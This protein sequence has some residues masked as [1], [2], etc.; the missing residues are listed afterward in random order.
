M[1]EP[2]KNEP[3]TNESAEAAPTPH[4]EPDGRTV[5]QRLLR[6]FSPKAN[7]GQLLAGLL[8]AVLGFALVVQVR[9][10]SDDNLDTLRESDLV[11]ILD[12]VSQRTSRLEDETDELRRTRDELLS[13]SNQ[14]QVAQQAAQERVDLL[15]ILA[16]TAPATGPGIQLTITDPSG[17]L[18]AVTLLDAVQELRDAGAEAMQVGDVRIVAS[19]S[20]V[21]DGDGVRVDGTLV[22]SPYVFRVIGDPDTLAPALGIPGGVLATVKQSQGGRANVT[23]KDEVVVDALRRVSEPEYARPAETPSVSPTS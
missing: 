10:A 5:R 2:A 22:H 8:C 14:Q 19:T 6:A 13:S 3:A 20:F 18:G 11:R 15:S 12:D 23:E 7:R 17:E 16:G 9:Q 1:N 4:E 21:N